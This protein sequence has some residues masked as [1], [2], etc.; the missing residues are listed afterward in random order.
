MPRGVAALSCIYGDSGDCCAQ[1]RTV[2]PARCRRASSPA[3]VW[4]LPA[5][6]PRSGSPTR[7]PGASSVT[8]RS[9]FTPHI[10]N[11]T[12]VLDRPGRQHGHR[13]RQLH[14]GAATPTSSTTLTRNRVFAFDATT[15][16]DQHD[17]QPRDQR[18]RVQGPADRRAQRRLR[19][20]QLQHAPQAPCQPQPG[21]GQRHQR[22]RRSP[23]SRRRPSTARSATSRSSATACSSPASSPTSAAV[24]QQCA[25][26]AQRHHR[27]RTTPTSPRVIAGW[28]RD[29]TAHPGDVTD[30]LAD[31][32]QRRR[33]PSSTAVGNFTSV[34]GADPLADR[35]RSTSPAPRHTPCRRGS[36]TSSRQACSVEVRDLRDRRRVLPRRQLLR[37]LH[38]PAPS[39]A[40][41]AAS[42]APPAVTWSPA[43]RPAATRGPTPATVDGVHRRRLHLD[44][45]GHRQR[46]LRRWP[47]EARRTTRSGP[48]NEAGGG[49]V[50]P[51]RHRRPEHAS[52]ACPY[53][54]NPTRT[55][56]VGSPGHAR[57]AA[58]GSGSAPTPTAS[59]HYEYH[60]RI[61]MLP[62]AGGDD[63]ARRWPTRP[64]PGTVYSR[65]SPAGRSST[66]AASTARTGVASPANAPN[67]AAP[68]SSTV[69]AFMV[70]GVLYTATNGELLTKRTFNGTDLR[71]RVHG[72]RRRT[73]GLRRPT[74][75]NTDVPIDHQPLLRTTAGCS[76]PGRGRPR[77]SGAASRPRA[78]SSASSGS[79]STRSPAST[80]PRCAA[81]SS[82]TT[83]STSPTP[84]DGCSAP[85]WAWQRT[86]RA[87]A[88]TQISGPGIDCQTWNSRAMFVYQAA[89]Q[90]T[91][92]P[93]IP[94]A[95]V[96][97]HRPHLLLRLDRLQ[98][99]GTAASPRSCGSSATGST[100]PPRPR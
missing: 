46:R 96:Q 41:P 62:L 52:T 63:P 39:A 94:V 83:S 16:A 76:S 61:A 32:Q 55:R 17:L 12:I 98:R 18:H 42:P 35:A 80:T 84:P 20:R 57:H 9:G 34:N 45:R 3:S 68:W 56:G 99:P 8:T 28:H 82:P 73:P 50:E 64:C 67:G 85:T 86:G 5:R 59:V 44:R 27:V 25:R 66:A 70:N 19:R 60:A 74:W 31:L 88:P 71:T 33:T 91:N 1:V 90:Q 100:R 87:A 58:R 4:L 14:P 37:R 49:A 79:P 54:W 53:S 40:A 15:G 10:L 36:P 38:R 29:P 51:P 81:P 75:H 95:D 30:V 11:G 43:S 93:P 26:L 24:A 47:P 92:P 6:R 72:R 78:T 69:G 23:A 77:C 13:R 7:R 21:Q 2:C 97:L 22:R 89:G 65:R 48:A